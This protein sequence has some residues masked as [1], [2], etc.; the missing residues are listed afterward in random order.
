MNPDLQA[1][2]IES[3]TKTEGFVENQLPLFVEAYIEYYTFT[4][5][6]GL[7]ILILFSILGIIASFFVMKAAIR[8]GGDSI[9]IGGFY[10]CCPYFYTD[11]INNS[12]NA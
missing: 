9:V 11:W 5:L 6:I 4:C 12:S 2:L 8:D 3:I 7:I 1:K 10:F